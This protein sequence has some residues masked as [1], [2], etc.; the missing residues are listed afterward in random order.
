MNNN[1]VSRLYYQFYHKRIRPHTDKLR[2]AAISLSDLLLAQIYNGEF[3]HYDI[4]IKYMVLEH[5]F[6]GLYPDAW[7]TYRTLQMFGD[8]AY[9]QMRIDQFKNVIASLKKNG[10][11]PTGT[12]SVDKNLLIR[13]GSHRTAM[14]LFYTAPSLNVL[15]NAIP[16]ESEKRIAEYHQYPFSSEERIA[17]EETLT[18]LMDK[19]NVP[20][21]IVL[22]GSCCDEAEDVC[23]VLEK[24]GKVVS[25]KEYLPDEVQCYNI[26]RELIDAADL[27]GRKHDAK[28]TVNNPRIAVIQLKLSSPAITTV[29]NNELKMLR[30]IINY[31]IPVIKQ[32]SEIRSALAEE[33][34][35]KDSQL[36]IPLNF[37]QNNKFTEILKEL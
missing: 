10:Y 23:K 14:A 7:K 5:E 27:Y 31:R 3:C 35:I 16:Y 33:T 34:F 29:E 24:F 15:F 2:T 6:N 1:P 17:I 4:V 11:M 36:F 32:S 19:V 28:V 21:N 22:F 8:E 30:R 9:T 13:D 26:C 12:M 20:L 18:Q 37:Y 25:C